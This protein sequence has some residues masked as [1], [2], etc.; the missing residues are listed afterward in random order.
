MIEDVELDVK[1]R[2]ELDYWGIPMPPTKNMLELQKV[3]DDEPQKA[4]YK[5]VWQW[6]QMKPLDVL[7]KCRQQVY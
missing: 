3:F 1:V 2:N 7:K 5:S 4:H 6:N